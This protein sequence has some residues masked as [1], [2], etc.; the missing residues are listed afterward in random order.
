MIR[1][2]PRSTLFP[3]T[4][5]F[6]SA[7]RVDSGKSPA[8]LIRLDPVLIQ[9]DRVTAMGHVEIGP[10]HVQTPVVLE[11]NV[12]YTVCD[13]DATRP[14]CTAPTDI[15]TRVVHQIHHNGRP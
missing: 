11:A 6:R 10:T 12:T 7:L 4:T 8:R 3:Y 5:L 2:P 14:A 9:R 1:R 13:R 15:P